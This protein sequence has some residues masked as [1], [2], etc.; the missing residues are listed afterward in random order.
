[1]KK[2]RFKPQDGIVEINYNT[3]NV[4]TNNSMLYS[5]CSFD[6]VEFDY[7]EFSTFQMLYLRKNGKIVTSLCVNK[8]TNIKVV[9]K[10]K[11]QYTKCNRNLEY[12][13][14][15]YKKLLKGGE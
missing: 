1:M 13:L 3:M 15:K 10:M 4:L 6:D 2:L 9:Y 14:A 7:D 12:L 8:N 5:M 11:A